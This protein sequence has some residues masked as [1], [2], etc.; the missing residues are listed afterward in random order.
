MFESSFFFQK[1]TDLLWYKNGH[2]KTIKHESS[3]KNSKYFSH[4]TDI[5][6]ILQKLRIGKEKLATCPGSQYEEAS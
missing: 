6:R 2:Q 4:F 3:Q 1:I 5:L